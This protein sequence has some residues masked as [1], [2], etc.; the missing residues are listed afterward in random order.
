MATHCHLNPYDKSLHDVAEDLNI[1]EAYVIEQDAITIDET[2]K[3]EHGA[4]A[5]VIRVS[6]HGANCRGKRVHTILTEF[7]GE[8]RLDLVRFVQECRIT[9]TFRHPNIV[10]YFGVCM[11]G[12]IPMLIMEELA[13]NLY[14]FLAN[15]L[16]FT[17]M[18]DIFETTEGEAPGPEGE[19]S[20]QE[21]GT[22]GQEGETSVQEGET[23]VQERGTP[24]Q[25]GETSVQEGGTP[26]QEGETSVQE[27]EIHVQEGETP[28][29]EGETPVQN[30][31]TQLCEC[32]NNVSD[33]RQTMLPE[34]GVFEEVA[35]AI[36]KTTPT[37]RDNKGECVLIWCT[38]TPQRE[39]ITFGRTKL[40]LRFMLILI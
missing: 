7:E 3:F 34:E 26:G 9:N 12:P 30:G 16:D 27:G 40:I 11:D 39:L 28:V 15:P 14:D 32:S 10:Q 6:Y 18:E 13:C 2:E 36:A 25:E 4:Y 1:P 19:T 29:Q 5:K 22:P 21:G 38:A 20:V 33:N 31:T 24:G 8:P 37:E 35:S 23:S 17:N